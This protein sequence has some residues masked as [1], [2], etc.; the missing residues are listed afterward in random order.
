MS[1]SKKNNTLFGREAPPDQVARDRDMVQSKCNE[2]QRWRRDK[3]ENEYAENRVHVHIMVCFVC[4]RKEVSQ[5]RHGISI[6]CAW[7]HV[8]N[9]AFFCQDDKRMAA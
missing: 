1:G 4:F 9:C 5:T 6:S 3:I 7:M 8:Q 2:Q